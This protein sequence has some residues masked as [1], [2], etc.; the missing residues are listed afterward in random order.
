L[1]DR[2]LT[3]IDSSRGP[4]NAQV[5]AEGRLTG[6]LDGF[7]LW[8][9]SPIVGVG[10]GGF[11][12]ASGRGYNAHNVY[13][14]VLGEMGTL[15]AVAFISLLLAFLANAWEARRLGRRL[16]PAEDAFPAEVSRAVSRTV[17]LL[18]LLG[19]AGHNLYRYNWIWLAGFEV[20]AVRCLRLRAAGAASVPR[21]VPRVPRLGL[22]VAAV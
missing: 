17:L 4:E 20:V 5:S 14:Q 8:E 11:G 15:G 16:G 18:L 22:A 10:P 13:G 12:L 19:C 6:L 7:K 1:Q 3:I 21:F 9:R 2:F